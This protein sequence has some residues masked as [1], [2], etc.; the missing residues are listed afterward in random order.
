VNIES[1]LAPERT[2]CALTAASKKR[3]LEEAAI[4]IADSLPG[5]E[6]E[7]LFGKLIN[8]EKIGTTGIGHGIAI[9]H[10][11]LDGCK[12]IVGSILTLSNAVDFQAFDDQPVNILFVLLVPTEEVDE[13]LQVLAM[14]AEKF[15]SSDY[16]EK[17]SNA[18]HDSELYEIA[19]T[20][21]YPDTKQAL[22]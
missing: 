8:R 20:D 16:R 22:R 19:I 7:E 13:H 17:L 1:I 2:Y 14:L 5:V 18:T 4:R 3:I 21:L 6:A 12:N 10:C 9:P 11:R 15:E